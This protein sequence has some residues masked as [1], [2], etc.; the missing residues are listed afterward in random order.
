MSVAD[1][2]TG[3]VPFE[4][5]SARVLDTHARVAPSIARLPA[6]GIT[7][8]PDDWVAWLILHYGLEAI[9]PVVGDGRRT[10]TEGRRW[11]RLRGTNA[12]TESYVLAWLGL[13]GL[14]VPD[15]SGGAG[16]VE[17]EPP[18]DWRRDWYQ[19][20]LAAALVDRPTLDLL[21]RG[22]RLSK[23]AGSRLGRIYGG[24]DIRPL[25]GEAARFEAC[26][27]DDWSGVRL[28]GVDPVLSFGAVHGGVI[29]LAAAV[30]AAG[31]HVTASAS[32]AFEGG[33]IWDRSRLDDEM[34]EPAL[35]LI[36]TGV[37][38]GVSGAVTLDAAP[39]PVTPWPPRPWTAVGFEAMG[40]PD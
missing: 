22:D 6:L 36:E 38:V 3:N 17:E 32:A 9:Y 10:L 35:V 31:V 39:W 5:A 20:A 27:W 29:D 2:I 37:A 12:A 34:I 15:R 13:D 24:L 40:G 21:I 30:T 1:L 18:H 7:D 26:L 4:R 8:V 25:R 28:P 23:D 16:P 19:I 33:A 11:Q 14:M